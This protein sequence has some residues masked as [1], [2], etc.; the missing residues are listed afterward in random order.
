MKDDFDFLFGSWTIRNRFLVGRLRGSTEWIE[1]DGTLDAWPLLDGLGNVDSFAA[2]RD[3]RPYRGTSFRLFNPR[4]SEWS[5]WWADTIRTG[6]L[7]PPMVGRFDGDHGAF[8]GEEEVDGR[9]VLCRFD[10]TRGPSPR[11]QQAFSDDGGTTWET[12]WVVDFTRV[13]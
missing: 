4:T 3:G 12:N 2:V 9:K 8:F 13:R 7:Q 10:W 1:F 6:E 11:W 5:I